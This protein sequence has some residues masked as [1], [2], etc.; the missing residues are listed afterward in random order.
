MSQQFGRRASLWVVGVPE[1]TQTSQAQHTG[2]LSTT[3]QTG[4]SG[5]PMLQ[6]VTVTSPAASG[7]LP[8]IDLSQLRFTF[9]VYAVDEETPPYAVITVYNLSDATARSVLN[10]QF[11]EVVLQVGYQDAGTFGQIFRGTIKQAFRGRE[12]PTTTFL[13]IVATDSDLLYNFGTVGITLKAGST[14][15]Q[16][17]NAIVSQMAIASPEQAG[18]SSVVFPD[19]PLGPVL[20]RGKVLFGMGRA[21]LRDWGSTAG[22]SWSI[23]NGKLRLISDTGYLPG[24]AV[25]LNSKTGMVGMPQQTDQGIKVRCLINPSL[26]VG[27]LVKLNNKDV[28]PA[29]IDVRY[30]AINTLSR[31]HERDD[32]LYRIYVLEYSGDTR[33]QEWYADLIMLAVDATVPGPN[34]GVVP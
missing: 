12:N 9:K 25:V 10:K 15:Q 23:Q 31:I 24:T 20:P 30:S 14:P 13:R 34:E 1:F 7:K 16:R 5:A 3:G 19:V 8:G 33:G 21:A 18:F 27:G 26:R 22:V 11:T 4:P 6:E 32:G 29:Q 28:I 2:P 17:L